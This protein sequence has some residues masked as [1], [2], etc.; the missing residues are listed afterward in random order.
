MDVAGSALI[1]DRRINAGTR[2]GVDVDMA[3][4]TDKGL[5]GHVIEAGPTSAKVSSC[6]TRAR[7]S[8]TLVQRADSASLASSRAIW[9]TRPCPRMVNIQTADVR[10]AMSS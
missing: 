3:V 10:K 2:D 5:V 4:V 7:R 9:T 6:S 1:G 8:G